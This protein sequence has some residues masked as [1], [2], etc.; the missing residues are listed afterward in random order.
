MLISVQNI[1]GQLR[2]SSIARLHDLVERHPDESLNVVR[3]WLVPEE[4]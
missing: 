4:R 2:A 3:R 1:E